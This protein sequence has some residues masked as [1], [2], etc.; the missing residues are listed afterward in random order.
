MKRLLLIEDD[1]FIARLY[2]GKFAVEGFE[3][4]IC[5]NEASAIEAV[6]MQVP[7]I[8]IVDL[9]LPGGS[10]LKVIENIRSTIGPKLPV[11]VFTNSY[12]SSMVEAAWKAGANKCL[13]KHDC[14]PRQLVEAVHS[15]L[16]TPETPA[17]PQPVPPPL[18]SS[19]TA[20]GTLP[21]REVS[22][23][24]TLVRLSA[25]L[26]D[27]G[28]SLRQNAK[29]LVASLTAQLQLVV[30]ASTPGELETHLSLLFKKL[31]SLT[32]NA[33]LAGLARVAQLCSA[34][35][36]LVQE[37]E[38][39]PEK[40]NSSVRRSIAQ[41]FDVLPS[42]FTNE[43]A[44]NLT[45]TLLVVVDDDKF[46]R[47]A[48]TAAISKAQLRSIAIEKPAMAIELARQNQ[49]DIVFLDVQMPGMDGFEL[50]AHIRQTPQNQKVPVVFVT[51]LNDFQTRQK[52]V[53]HG[54]ADLIAK[55]FLLS[56]VAVKVLT[57]LLRPA[58]R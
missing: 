42:L 4:E 54:G 16:S 35:E 12:L 31:H 3:V 39:N 8:A 18:Q 52:M 29:Q 43:N 25:N 44:A 20:Q 47:L 21:P 28:A 38:Q 50:C 30:R 24:E 13:T 48:L 11:I 34:L 6:R 57:Y 58:P 15:L 7:S 2:R 32:G 22:E 49:L 53:L 1:P 56:E 33:G 5:T 17:P 45:Q 37:L 51:G 36:A 10:G 23:T 14:T 40:V 26:S 9:M 46:S 55:P 19:T 27:L 41:A